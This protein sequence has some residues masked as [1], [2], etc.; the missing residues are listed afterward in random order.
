[1]DEPKVSGFRKDLVI[2]L[3]DEVVDKN[4]SNYAQNGIIE[5][6]ERLTLSTGKTMKY[7]KYIPD[8]LDLTVKA[9]F[10]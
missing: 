9:K 3:Y 7:F 1:M 8:T 5:I 10:L 2:S 4:A 6:C